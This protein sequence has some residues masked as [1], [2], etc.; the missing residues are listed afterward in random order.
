MMMNDY[1]IYIRSNSSEGMI[2]DLNH[3]GILTTDCSMTAHPQIYTLVDHNGSTR[4]NIIL[5]PNFDYMFKKTS[6]GFMMVSVTPESIKLARKHL[7]EKNGCTYDDSNNCE[8][9]MF[10]LIG[11]VVFVFVIF[12]AYMGK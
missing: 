3:N 5:H 4:Y 6:N 9:L 2:D 1:Y 8:R 7:A 10:T 12:M 11:I